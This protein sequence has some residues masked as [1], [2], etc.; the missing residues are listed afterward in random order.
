MVELELEIYNFVRKLLLTYHFSD[1][2]Y[3]GNCTIKP[4]STFT[5]KPNENQELESFCKSLSE[6]NINVDKGKNH[7]ASLRN[8]LNSLIQKTKQHEIIIK[9]ADKGTTV[10]V[11]SMNDY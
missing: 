4:I 8:T 1:L 6:T 11:I 3:T 9:S 7:M 2:N 10:R 5:L